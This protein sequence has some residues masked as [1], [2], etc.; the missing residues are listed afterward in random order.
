MTTRITILTVLLVATV[1]SAQTPS[2]PPSPLP[3]R[4]VTLFTSGVAYT[5]RGGEV[6]GDASVP[7]IFRTAQIN[8]I[9][10]SMVLLDSAGT[11]QPATYT[12]RDPIGRTLRAFA[13][14]LSENVSLASI[15]AQLRGATVTVETVN[16]GTVTGQIVSLET[17]QVAGDDNKPIMVS[18]LTLLGENGLTTVRLDP[19]RNIRIHD[20]RLNREFREA[21]TQLAAGADDQR[22][23][24]TL[25]FSGAGTR[26]VRVG[27]VMEAPLWKMSYRLVM[28]DQKPGQPPARPYLQGWALVENTSD[29]DW[30][31]VRLTLVSG[32]PVSFIQ[33]LYQPLYIPRP[34]VAP[35]VIASPYPQTHGGNLLE[36]NKRIAEVP[37]DR[38]AGPANAPGGPMGGAGF[39]G[40]GRRSGLAVP[41]AKVEA[42]GVAVTKPVEPATAYDMDSA[43]VLRKSVEAQASGAS[44]GELFQYNISNPINL[45]R[46]QAA[47]IPVVAQDVEVDRVSLYNADTGPKFPMNAVRLKNITTLHLKGGPITLFDGGNYAGDAKMED[48]PPGDNRLVTYAVDLTVEGERQGTNNTITETSLALK[49]GVLTATRKERQEVTYTFKSKA[50]RAKIIL[51]EHPF[52]SEYKLVSPEKPAERT[53]QLYRFA[54]TVQPN[55]TETLKVTTERPIFQEVRVMDAD[56]NSV[57]YY[58]NRKDISD[59]LRDTLQDVVQRRRKVQELQAQANAREAEIKSMGDDQERIRK[60]MQALDRMS[61]LYKRYVTELDAQETRLQNLRQESA[62]LRK[63]AGD[64]EREL[65]AYLDSLAIPE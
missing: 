17:R 19:E 64:A 57:A 15:L 50:P 28:N 55:K 45:P 39:G 62:R 23:Q 24:V 21:L 11:V 14:D 34:V 54:V 47:M 6:T 49:R 46:Q 12:A 16:K 2:V 10:K 25:H 36:D 43:T 41:G 20:E 38:A 7:L 13:V 27:Y 31:D 5:E 8:D 48:I 4:S 33:D 52:N 18:F 63:E 58:A 51:V 1:G 26:P 60:N 22:R 65:R 44:L 30:K 56:L 61:P 32:R 35:D 40:G 59:K 37:A 3:V 53:A 42:G 29:E 9:L